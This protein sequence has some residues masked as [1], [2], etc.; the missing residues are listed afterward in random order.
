MSENNDILK[1]KQEIE[2][3]KA[4][5]AQLTSEKGK[6]LLAKEVGEAQRAAILAQLP[7]SDVKALEGK[8]AVDAAATTEIQR[9][10]HEAT[11]SLAKTMAH[12]IHKSF[13]NLHTILIYDESDISKVSHYNT[14]MRQLN[15][16]SQGYGENGI[17]GKPVA[18]T[19]SRAV[20]AAMPLLA[21]VVVGSVVKSAIDLVSLFR[22]DVD[23]KGAAV[24]F[25]NA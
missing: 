12:D 24:T 11:R 17:Q 6:A 9:L 13:P 3:L 10:A 18:K 23:I 1:L 22:T 2:T 20:L 25:Y 4:A 5:N 21:P 15:L 7:S 14:V 16:L 19:P 8:V